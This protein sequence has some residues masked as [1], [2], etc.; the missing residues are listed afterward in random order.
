MPFNGVKVSEKKHCLPFTA[1]GE[2]M[3]AKN[4]LSY[5]FALGALGSSL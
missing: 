4:N 5:I 3:K 2:V 1:R